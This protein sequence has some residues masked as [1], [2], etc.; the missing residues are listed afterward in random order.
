[1]TTKAR[2]F[3]YA[4][5]FKGAVKLSDFKLVDEVLPAVRDGQFLAEATYISVDPYLRNLVATL[6]EGSVMMGRQVAK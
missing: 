3:I 1:M 6:P 4:K 2:V 5:A